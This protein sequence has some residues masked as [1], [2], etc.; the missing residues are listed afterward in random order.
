MPT[1]GPASVTP[2]GRGEGGRQCPFDHAT[3]ATS[4]TPANGTQWLPPRRGLLQ[5][6]TQPTADGPSVTPPS[7]IF[8]IYSPLASAPS[9]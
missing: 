8:R 5:V 2:V 4:A 9:S 6:C 1:P 7:Q 3:S